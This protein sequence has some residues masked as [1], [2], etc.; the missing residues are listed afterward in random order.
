L[1]VLD[2]KCLRNEMAQGYARSVNNGRMYLQTWGWR[3]SFRTTLNKRRMKGISALSLGGDEAQTEA[4]AIPTST[5]VL[6]WANTMALSIVHR[7]FLCLD[8]SRL[9]R[10]NHFHGR[11]YFLISQFPHVFP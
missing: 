3:D 10:G 4:S 2:S 7:T 5:R 8:S 9:W 1:V 11:R 6:A